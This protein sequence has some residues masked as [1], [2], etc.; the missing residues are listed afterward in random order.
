MLAAARW[1][2]SW[3]PLL[4]KNIIVVG[5]PDLE[6]VTALLSIDPDL[7]IQ[8]VSHSSDVTDMSAANPDLPCLAFERADEVLVHSILQQVID[9]KP[10]V[11]TDRESWNENA[12]FYGDL[13]AHLTGRSSASFQLHLFELGIDIKA[14]P[15]MKRLLSMRDVLEV[16]RKSAIGLRPSLSIAGEI[17]K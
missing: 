9:T 4:T 15:D 7:R 12:S 14:I 8:Y 6:K 1:A 17:V 3:G 2:Y 13:F 11:L 5:R 10:M 16:S